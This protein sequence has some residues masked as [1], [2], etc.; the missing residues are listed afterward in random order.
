MFLG[1]YI[2]RKSPLAPFFRGMGYV[3]GTRSIARLFF[4]MDDFAENIACLYYLKKFYK[5]HLP[6]DINILNSLDNPKSGISRN[7]IKE[8]YFEMRGVLYYRLSVSMGNKMDPAAFTKKTS[9]LFQNSFIPVSVDYLL[10]DAKRCGISPA[11]IFIA[12]V[13]LNLHTTQQMQAFFS[14]YSESIQQEFLQD[15]T[16]RSLLNAFAD[17]YK[18]DPDQMRDIFGYT[19][20]DI[21]IMATVYQ[22][23]LKNYLNMM[24]T[25]EFF[26]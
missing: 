11:V 5:E 15:F 1:D 6:Q 25:Y 9:W 24:K 3:R 26:Q 13:K 18:D 7:I 8:L 16:T 12:A 19:F 17:R 21:Q 23:E 20:A 2:V 4:K 10:T 14:T 22:D